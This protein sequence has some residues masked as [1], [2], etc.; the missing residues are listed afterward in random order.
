MRKRLS[1]RLAIYWILYMVVL[2][3]LE[4]HI[5]LNLIIKLKELFLDSME[6][7]MIKITAPVLVAVRPPTKRNR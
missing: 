6:Q 1:L 2:A 7:L 5:V 4:I 3:V